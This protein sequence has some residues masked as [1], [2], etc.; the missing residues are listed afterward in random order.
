MKV[1]VALLTYNRKDFYKRTLHSLKQTKL[2]F[3]LIPVDNGST[4]GTAGLVRGQKGFCNTDGNR[5]IGHGF[6]LAMGLALARKPDIV[7]FTADDYFYCPG[8]LEHLTE[9]W[10][11]A[12]KHAAL[13]SLTMEPPYRW[14]TI[15]GALHIGGCW[16]VERHTVPGANWSFRAGLWRQLEPLIPDDS[17]HYDRRVCEALRKK[18]GRIYALPLAEHLGAGSRSWKA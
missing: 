16:V 7:L 15:L 14:N 1:V 6:R 3:D 17:H 12:P 13:C 5:T 10:E 8:W 9:F 18:G 2:P 4:D 11:N